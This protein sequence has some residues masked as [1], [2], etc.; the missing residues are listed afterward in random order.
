M[1]RRRYTKISYD[2][3]TPKS[4]QM[5]LPSLRL[6][7]RKTIDKK[8]T[9]QLPPKV[10]SKGIAEPSP[11]E[12]VPRMGRRKPGTA[13]KGA[14]NQQLLPVRAEC[15]KEAG[16]KGGRVTTE[17][18]LCPICKDMMVDAAVTPCCGNCF[19]HGCARLLLLE[20]GDNTCFTCNKPVSPDD[21][22]PYPALRWII[23]CYRNPS[24]CTWCTIMCAGDGG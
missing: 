15:K 12:D 4:P 17:S 5:S 8:K 1:G 19:C 3:S 23:N 14:K 22:V 21:L 13:P 6:T 18:L 24:W 11:T 7:I 2:L 10:G 16:F 20:S 9:K